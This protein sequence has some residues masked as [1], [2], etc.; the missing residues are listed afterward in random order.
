MQGPKT[1]LGE[2]GQI[3]TFFTF[4]GTAECVDADTLALSGMLSLYS[5][6]DRPEY[7]P[8]RSGQEPG[9]LAGCRRSAVPVRAVGIH[10]QTA[11]PDDALGAI[12]VSFF[13]F[14]KTAS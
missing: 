7:R 11:S 14:H 4:S 5:A 2:R 8:A 12:T 1:A 6:V 10:L 3:I 13:P 9:R